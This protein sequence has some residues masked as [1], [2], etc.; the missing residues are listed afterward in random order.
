MSHASDIPGA[1]VSI[2]HRIYGLLGHHITHSLS[3]ELHGMI[4]EYPYELFDLDLNQ[5]DSFLKERPF[6]AINVTIPY[7]ELAYRSA[8]VLSDQAKAIGACNTLVNHEGVLYGYNTDY[9]GFGALLSEVQ[10]DLSESLKDIAGRKVLVLGS[11]GASKAVQAVL[12]DLGAQVTVISRSG[13]HTYIELEDDTHADAQYLINTTPVG[14]SPHAPEAPI[15]KDMLSHLT[16][17]KAVVDLIYNPAITL[18]GFWAAQ[19]NIAYRSGMIMLVEQAIEAGRLFGELND[20]SDVD[21]RSIQQKLSV[22]SKNIVLIGMPSAGKTTIGRKLAQISNRTFIDTDELF[23]KRYEMSPSSYIRSH[24]ED[25]FRDLESKIV[26]DV[27]N[28]KMHIISCG[29]GVICRNDNFY[30]LRQ[31]SEVI[32]IKR[33]VQEL[34][35]DERP[36][37]EKFGI[38]NL[39]EQRKDLYTKFATIELDVQAD[40]ELSAKLIA[41]HLDI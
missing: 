6:D 26:K 30:A 8:D 29:G 24:G 13:A 35:C 39:Y 27:S 16:S 31:N 38:E 1:Q 25:A 4:G 20:M 9:H 23:E 33:P 10:N 22:Q 18:L 14:M 41:A 11:G 28:L 12:Q 34:I 40:S 3:P 2:N 7:K 5:A 21:A 37:S 17:L 19:H 32:Y 36:I 15:T